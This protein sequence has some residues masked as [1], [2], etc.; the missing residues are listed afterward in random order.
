MNTDCVV[1]LL[2]LLSRPGSPRITQLDLSGNAVLDWRCAYVLARALGAVDLTAPEQQ[3]AALRPLAAEVGS[4]SILGGPGAAAGSGPKAAAGW[5]QGK[6]GT[7]GG[8][9]GLDTVA[10]LPLARLVLADVKIGDKGAVAM[11][12]ALQVSETLKVSCFHG[13]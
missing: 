3:L 8:G 6:S 9:S 11:A 5:G 2:A 7:G 4:A 10:V 1:Q 12:A 13:G